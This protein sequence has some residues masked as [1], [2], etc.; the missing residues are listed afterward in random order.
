[1]TKDKLFF[2]SLSLSLKKG[3]PGIFMGNILA[4]GL[5]SITLFLYV[6]EGSQFGIHAE[7]TTLHCF[8]V[9]H[10]VKY[11]HHTITWMGFL[12]YLQH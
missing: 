7:S 5:T 1:M 6:C 3:K 4:S 9:Y 2:L 10:V 11:N 8:V 12:R